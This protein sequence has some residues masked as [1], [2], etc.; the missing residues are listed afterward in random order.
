MIPLYK[1]LNIHFHLHKIMTCK[2]YKVWLSLLQYHRGQ[3]DTER[4]M[5]PTFMW[6]KKIL[7]IM[8]QHFKVK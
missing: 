8:T 3:V 6:K 2:K 5:S 4:S 7:K 1:T